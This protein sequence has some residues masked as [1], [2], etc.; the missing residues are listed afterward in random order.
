MYLVR[1]SFSACVPVC[2]YVR[3][4]VYVCVSVSVCVCARAHYV[5]LC[6]GLIWAVLIQGWHVKL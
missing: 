5:C 1:A 4:C 6:H 3:V 2:F